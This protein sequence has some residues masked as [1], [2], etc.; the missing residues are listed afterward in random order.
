MARYCA[1]RHAVR[2]AEQILLR[3]Q[4]PVLKYFAARGRHLPASKMNIS[5]HIDPTGRSATGTTRHTERSVSRY[6][7]GQLFQQTTREF[8]NR[9]ERVE[10]VVTRE[11][12]AP[13]GGPH[14]SGRPMPRQVLRSVRLAMPNSVAAAPAGWTAQ[15]NGPA[16]PSPAVRQRPATPGEVER[17]TDQV[18]RAIDRRIGAMQERFGRF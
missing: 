9:I 18:V 13:A 4:A 6:S 5:I 17:L 2:R 3:T 11:N 15:L 10:S 14:N 16:G 12:F 8:F 1:M 7:A